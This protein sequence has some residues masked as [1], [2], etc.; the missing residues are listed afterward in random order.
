MTDITDWLS[1]EI[2]SLTAENEAA[3]RHM[4]D[5]RSPTSFGTALIYQQQ[6]CQIRSIRIKALMDVQKQLIEGPRF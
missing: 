6:L 4:M 5:Y 1:H 3:M 2:E